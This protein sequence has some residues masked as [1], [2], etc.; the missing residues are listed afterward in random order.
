MFHLTTHAFFKAL[1]FLGAG[2]V[3]LALHHEQDIWK[4]GGAAQENAGDVLDVSGRHAGAGGPVAVERILSARTPFSRHA[5]EQH[6]YGLFALGVFVAILTTFYMFRLVFVVFGSAP[7][8]EQP[9][10][11]TNRLR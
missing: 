6:A 8:S 3:I 4:M 10:T 9:G 11:R 7:K 1:L 2:S 5:L